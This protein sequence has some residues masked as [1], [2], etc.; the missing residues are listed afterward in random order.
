MK[1][2]AVIGAGLSG[3]LSAYILSRGT[4]VSITVFEKGQA[5]ADR[6]SD[7]ASDMLSGVGGAGTLSGGKL[8]FPPASFGVWNKTGFI[9]DDFMNFVKTCL[10]PL[11]NA[12]IVESESISYSSE[13][14][15]TGIFN[16][17][18]QTRLLLADEMRLFVSGLLSALVEQNV[19]IKTNTE[20][21]N[22]EKTNN[23][24]S[25]FY[26]G[27]ESGLCADAFDYVIVA[28]GRSSAKN[29][30][31]WF[32]EDNVTQVSPDLGI[33]VS[34]G[35]EENEVFANHGR[36]IKLKTTYGNVGVRT[37]CVCSGGDNALVQYENR[38]Y[39]DGHFGGGLSE[40]VNFGI[41]ARNKDIV[42]VKNGIDY[43]VELAHL[44]D[45]DIS[46]KDVIRHSSKFLTSQSRF[47]CVFE[48]IRRFVLQMRDD[49]LI[50]ANLDKYQVFMPSIDRLNPVISTNKFF[51]TADEN[52]YVVGD[53]AGISRGFVQSMW[54]AYY[55][56]EH[57]LWKIMAEEMPERRLNDD[58]KRH[59]DF[60]R[61]RISSRLFYQRIW[62]ET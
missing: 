13:K 38:L 7:K 33:R 21:I 50:S 42:G 53:A 32:A 31:D 47:G 28:S 51:E 56:S 22:F 15:K 1:K 2:I 3:L 16:K 41:L 6:L 5:Y 60:W 55:A 10:N 19:Q 49:G 25:V 57:I 58:H 11:L 36:D 30:V 8:C 14:S 45:K 26:K 37:F 29:I 61:G 62:Q 44:V 59:P 12:N 17:G 52:I 35:D 54:S 23:T 4:D 34:I 48:A 40:T 43:C 9:V 27:G 20:F 46:L 18:F 24:I 39:Y